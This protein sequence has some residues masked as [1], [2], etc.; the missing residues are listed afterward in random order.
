MAITERLNER[1]ENGLKIGLFPMHAYG[2]DVGRPDD[3]EM[4]NDDYSQ[5][6]TDDQ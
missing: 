4:M 3:F 6:T 5:S 1:R 2:V